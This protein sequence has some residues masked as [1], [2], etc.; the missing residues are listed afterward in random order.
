M[1]AARV[2][3]TKLLMGE[4]RASLKQKNRFARALFKASNLTITGIEQ[5]CNQ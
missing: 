1:L 2:V 3:G 4:R 5:K